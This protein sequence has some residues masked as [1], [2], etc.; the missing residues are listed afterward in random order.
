MDLNINTWNITLT[1]NNVDNYDIHT[2]ISLYFLP[3]ND[4]M[5]YLLNT[6]QD[7]YS[8][9]EKFVYDI[10]MFHF[11]QLGIE[12][13][14][15]DHFIEFWF[16]YNYI[17]TCH[18]DTDEYEHKFNSD[19]KYKENSPIL[20]CITYLSE[21]NI[22]TF[23]TDI[24]YNDNINECYSEKNKINLSFP[25]YLKQI[26]FNGGNYFHGTCKVFEN[27]THINRKILS[28]ILWDKKKVKVPYFDSKIFEYGLYS[29]H[30]IKMI[31]SYI[32]KNI[33]LTNIHKIDS[34]KGE[35]FIN[36][37]KNNEYIINKSFFKDLINLGNGKHN[38]LFY[39]FSNILNENNFENYELIELS[40]KIDLNSDA[41][42]KITEKNMESCVKNKEQNIVK[43]D[44]FTKQRMIEN[45][46]FDSVTC[47]WIINS[48][49]KYIM[50]KQE[51]SSLSKINIDSLKNIQPFV[52]FSLENLFKTK[53]MNFYH[54]INENEKFI[55]QNIHVL[56]M[57]TNNTR[58]NEEIVDLTIKIVLNNN[59]NIDFKDGTK[60]NLNKGDFITHQSK[61]IESMTVSANPCYMLVANIVWC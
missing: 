5:T 1:Q 34:P 61:S 28:I 36:K 20:T 30:G 19:F 52:L 25:K 56:K 43:N 29:I 2:L 41:G 27:E 8:F 58:L 16:K 50:K 54:L 49:E 23:I 6:N 42:I 57:D 3:R 12:Y 53:I 31:D 24:N 18:V 40:N 38:Y 33:Q 21:S 48:T 15:D 46:F 22:P 7:K 47:D 13:N 59:L 9:I 17:S 51:R 26:T 60:M 14:K 39:R 44:I 10:A 11:K 4:N 32:D 35:F 45:S 55:I 37:N